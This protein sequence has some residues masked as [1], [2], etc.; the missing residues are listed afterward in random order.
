M[1]ENDWVA[2]LLAHA[3][4]EVQEPE[5]DIREPE[6]DLPEP[7]NPEDED[8]SLETLFKVLEL[9]PPAAFSEIGSVEGAATTPD[10]LGRPTVPGP[11][12]GE[13]DELASRVD[14]IEKQLNEIIRLLRPGEHT[15]GTGGGSR[16]P[17]AQ[18]QTEGR[19]QQRK[20]SEPE[21]AP[22]APGGTDQPP[23]A[24][25]RREGSPDR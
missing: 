1:S 18:V 4:V 24:R 16:R 10:Y 8:D 23:D 21:V 15:S 25:A 19:E 5:V 12:G 14:H 11:T 20:P 7:R 2:L 6:S 13:R 3:R 22:Q 17:R 9:S